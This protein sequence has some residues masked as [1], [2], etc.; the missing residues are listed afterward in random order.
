MRILNLQH[1]NLQNNYLPSFCGWLLRKD[2]IQMDE[3]DRLEQALKKITSGQAMHQFAKQ[4]TPKLKNIIVSAIQEWYDS[5]HPQAYQRTYNFMSVGDSAEVRNAGNS[6]IIK[7]SSNNM[8][9]YKYDTADYV[10]EGIT[11]YGYHGSP[12]KAPVSEPVV[13][14]IEQKGHDLLADDFASFIEKFMNL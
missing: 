10:F 3:L 1:L 4:E 13:R 14:M 7:I 11:E 8:I 9:D 6:I 5:Y 12:K 2:G